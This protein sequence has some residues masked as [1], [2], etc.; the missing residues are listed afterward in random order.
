MLRNNRWKGG[1]KERSFSKKEES[2]GARKLKMIIHL[3]NLYSTLLGL[4]RKKKKTQIFR[5]LLLLP[6]LV[7]LWRSFLLYLI[8]CHFHYARCVYFSRILF[9]FFYLFFHFTCKFHGLW[10][11]LCRVFYTQ[12]VIRNRKKIGAKEKKLYVTLCVCVCV[13]YSRIFYI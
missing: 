10:C 6:F 9:F 5:L 4:R 13:F 11:L 1:K 2:F 12:D 8:T 7:P 3:L